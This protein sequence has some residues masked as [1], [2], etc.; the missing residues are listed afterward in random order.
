MREE[1]VRNDKGSAFKNR[2]RF[3][4]AVVG[5][6]EWRASGNQKRNR[7]TISLI[8]PSIHPIIQPLLFSIYYTQCLRP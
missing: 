6:G 4:I 5:C 3:E 8:H 7:S 1:K 2:P